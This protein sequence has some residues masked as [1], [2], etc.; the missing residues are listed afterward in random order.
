VAAGEAERAARTR[1][2][3][4]WVL[5]K[6]RAKAEATGEGTTHAGR[7]R[8]LDLLGP[9]LGM[10]RDGPAVLVAAPRSTWPPCP[11]PTWTPWSPSSP[12]RAS[13]PPSRTG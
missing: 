6:L 7:V 13:R 2:D 4:D 9:H 1:L 5:V 3:A 11:T 10:W 12:A 8:A